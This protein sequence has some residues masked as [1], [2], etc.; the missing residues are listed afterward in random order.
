M[1]IFANPKVIF[2]ISNSEPFN[3]IE[4]KA[5]RKNLLKN[6][7]HRIRLWFLFSTHQILVFKNIFRHKHVTPSV[8]ELLLVIQK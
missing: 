2:T 6:K 4:L 3:Y 1:E 7:N 8:L 5:L